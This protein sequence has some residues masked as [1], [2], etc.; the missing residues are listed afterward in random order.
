MTLAI[1]VNSTSIEPT[2]TAQIMIHIIETSYL[3]TVVFIDQDKRFTLKVLP[4]NLETVKQKFQQMKL[5][6]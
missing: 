2:T 5:Q 6:N 3:L 1:L 4:Q